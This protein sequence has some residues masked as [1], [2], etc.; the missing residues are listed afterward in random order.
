MLA[1]AGLLLA[2]ATQI[3]AGAPQPVTGIENAFPAWSPDGSKILFQSNRSGEWHLYLMSPDGGNVRDLTPSMKDCRNPSFSP[4]GSKI[5]FY[6]AA[7]G[8]EEIY[9]MAADGSGVANLPENAAGDIHP[10][11]TPDGTKIIFNSLRDDPKAYDVYVMSADG[12]GVSRLTSTPEDETCAQL[13]PDG[14]R[15]VFLRGFPTG[16]D[17]IIVY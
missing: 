14:K 12:T 2:T 17:Q 13:S 6:S 1:T 3:A 5:V 4:D 15:L 8:N 9:V 11:W 7:S 10:H 16:N